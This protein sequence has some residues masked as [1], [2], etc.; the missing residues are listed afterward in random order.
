MPASAIPRKD[1]N[2]PIHP[3][4]TMARAK[5][6]AVLLLE[7]PPW[8]RATARGLPG[9]PAGGQ[10]GRSPAT[11]QCLAFGPPEIVGAPHPACIRGRSVPVPLRRENAR[12]GLHRPGPGHPQ[13]PYPHRAALRPAETPRPVASAFRR[14]L[15][16]PVP[17]DLRTAVRRPGTGLLPP[18]PSPSTFDV[19]GG[20]G[21]HNI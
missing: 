17:K 10:A 9:A 15:P 16:R 19:R 2:T 21:L 8:G 7:R 5:N 6:I 18:S 11:R 20:F 12:R 3:A 1:P 4:I 14:L 13:G